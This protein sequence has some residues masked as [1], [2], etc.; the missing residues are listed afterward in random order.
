[1]VRQGMPF[2]KSSKLSD[3]DEPDI[4]DVS[5]EDAQLQE[6]AELA[7][8]TA[9]EFIVSEDIGSDE[10]A[11]SEFYDRADQQMLE[12]AM[13]A[14]KSLESQ[15]EERKIINEY[16][17]FATDTDFADYLRNEKGITM[18][19][20][21]VASARQ[22][23]LKALDVKP[24]DMTT[25][26]VE[27]QQEKQLFAKQQE[28]EVLK[29]Q[30]ADFDAPDKNRRYSQYTIDKKR[31]Q[32]RKDFY[33][34][35]PT[36]LDVGQGQ[37][38]SKTG[39]RTVSMTKPYIESE[40]A[41]LEADIAA[42]RKTM[43][44]A[45]EVKAAE[46]R[47]KTAN[48]GITDFELKAA[49]QNPRDIPTS[50]VK[51][52][53]D[54]VKA[55][56]EKKI[57]NLKGETVK[58]DVNPRISFEGNYPVGGSKT[59]SKEAGAG[60]NRIAGPV[61]R[62]DVE[63]NPIKR[64]ADGR[65]IGGGELTNLPKETVVT[66]E[67]GSY[68]A[69]NKVERPGKRDPSKTVL[70]KPEVTYSAT[71]N[72]EY[73][74]NKLLQEDADYA[75]EIFAQDAKI[76]AKQAEETVSQS[77]VILDESDRKLKKVSFTS[78]DQK[79]RDIGMIQSGPTPQEMKY[80][81]AKGELGG[82]MGKGQA[83]TMQET[84]AKNTQYGWQQQLDKDVLNDP[85][86]ETLPRSKTTGKI[87]PGQVKYDK[88]LKSFAYAAKDAEFRADIISKM[89]K[90]LQTN[91][92]KGNVTSNKGTVIGRGEVRQ[93]IKPSSPS[94]KAKGDFNY[95][96]GGTGAGTGF[97]GN[98]GDPGNTMIQGPGRSGKTLASELYYN[99]RIPKRRPDAPSTGTPE[100][101]R[102]KSAA[103]DALSGGESDALKQIRKN[104]KARNAAIAVAAT[105]LGKTISNIASK[106]NPALAG[107]SLL[108]QKVFDDIL[109]PK[110]PEA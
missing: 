96:T 51:G 97:K 18:P 106:A 57:T 33:T 69:G 53:K 52:G 72:R 39:E 82:L 62:V 28:L 79:P 35:G 103:M 30:L 48:P 102:S 98:I 107:L 32:I 7:Q 83:E 88:E 43:G 47:L 3:F 16:N 6:T 12:E 76:A 21:K 54:T 11:R 101:M 86:M 93:R 36:K 17:D 61:G 94:S 10:P 74:L 64:T 2:G 26:R 110:K 27:A 34:Q 49:T 25:V 1:M 70:A 50:P 46:T 71:G 24:A 31:Q 4:P 56:E 109:Y 65:P 5:A 41:A 95:Q 60:T 68:V 38:L 90:D 85:R 23:Y 55:L 73:V 78:L 59:A 45:D 100:A 58:Y 67:I 81:E 66:R 63:G 20:D 37:P 14:Q 99:P 87:T 42:Q 8:E 77:R 108:P 105:K 40:I 9:D 84:G 13:P 92:V 104:Q 91:I 44:K 89:D 75:A 80:M 29:T 15:L 22:K 19:K